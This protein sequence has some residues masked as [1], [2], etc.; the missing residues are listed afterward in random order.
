MRVEGSSIARDYEHLP[1]NSRIKKN[2]LTYTLTQNKWK[3]MK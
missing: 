3:L 1:P 2:F